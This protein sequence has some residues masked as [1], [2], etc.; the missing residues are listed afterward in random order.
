MHIPFQLKATNII[1]NNS[2][3]KT[4][5]KAIMLG[6]LSIPGFASKILVMSRMTVKKK[7]LTV[8]V[9]AKV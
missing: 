2:P 7:P 8:V 6:I 3:I 4:M 9:Q 5:C 1:E